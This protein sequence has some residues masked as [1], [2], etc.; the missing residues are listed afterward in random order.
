MRV[1]A[2]LLCV[3][4]PCVTG[5]AA[6]QSGPR[7]THLGLVIDKTG[8]SG[9][10]RLLL[11]ELDVLKLDQNGDGEATWPEI[12][13]RQQDI[14]TY[15]GDNLQVVANGGL[16][17]LRFDHLLYGSQM[18]EPALLAQLRFDAQPDIT[19]L[20]VDLGKFAGEV[21]IR[22]PD[23]GRHKRE[24][25]AASGPQDFTLASAIRGGF[26]QFIWQ[27][28]WH[29]WIGFDHILFLLVLLLPAVFR[30]TEQG[31]EVVPRFGT[32]LGQVLVIVSAFTIAH[33]ITLTCA[34]MRWIVLPG[35]LVESA[36]AASVFVAALANFLPR[37]AGGRGAWLAAGFGLLHGFG[38]ASALGEIA[39][40]AGRLWQSLLA[41]NIGVELGQLAIVTVF[42]PVAFLLRRTA[43]YRFGALYGGSAAAGVV[44]LRWFLQ[45]ALP[46]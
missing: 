12:E 1:L 25:S 36:I 7:P 15:L 46:A 35:R 29:I 3:L 2:F 4:L 20:T 11:S 14:E 37:T 31:R 45:R 28:M 32:A 40:G 44:A 30:R 10:W 24:V 42:L 34:A 21:E 8:L 18:G 22:W 43:F 33:S 23:G 38:F 26:L 19:Q 9:E 6:A 5:V 17:G 16:A 27:G 13:H 39:P 41:F